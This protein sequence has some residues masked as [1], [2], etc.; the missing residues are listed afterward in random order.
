MLSPTRKKSPSATEKKT[1]SAAAKASG[2]KPKR[3]GTRKDAAAPAPA[4]EPKESLPPPDL[5]LAYFCISP[6]RGDIVLVS[7]DLSMSAA[8]AYRL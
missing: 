1:R 4:E 5:R 3:G 2:V 7:T 8:D 6:P